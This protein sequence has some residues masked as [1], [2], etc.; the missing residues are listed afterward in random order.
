MLIHKSGKLFIQL[1]LNIQNIILF[2]YTNNCLA[3]EYNSID[4]INSLNEKDFPN[5]DYNNKPYFAEIM[6]N[7]T[8]QV[9][10]PVKFQCVVE[11]LGT[12]QVAWVRKD[13]HTLLA[14]GKEVISK[15]SR[16]D[17]SNHTDK[18][19]SLKLDPVREEDRGE[20]MCQ[21]N[22]SP[23]IDQ[24]AFLR[25][26]VPPYFVED[27][28]SSDTDVDENDSVSLRCTA[29]GFPAPTIEW[30]REDKESIDALS[31]SSISSSSDNKNVRTV[32][33]TFLNLSQVRRQHMGVYLCIA[34]NGIPNSVSKRIFLGV[35][36]P[37]LVWTPL[38]RVGSPLNGEVTLNCIVDAYPKPDCY[39]MKTSTRQ[40][41]LDNSKYSTSITSN[42]FK[43]EVTLTIKNVDY[44]DFTSYS[45]VGKN[46]LSEASG[47]IVLFEIPRPSTQRAVI[48][49]ITSPPSKEV[50]KNR[51]NYLGNTKNSLNSDSSDKEKLNF[52][53]FKTNS[54]KNDIPSEQ[55]T[56]QTEDGVTTTDDLTESMADS[57]SKELITSWSIG[58][59]IVSHLMITFN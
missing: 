41:I 25:V 46:V 55:I 9:G 1:I 59:L 15:N 42:S 22:S 29:R 20:Y 2:T 16:I 4:S 13:K 51:K 33:G 54:Y 35:K 44:Q 50:T 56:M 27:Q 7:V 24:S 34:S 17:V 3:K 23:V 30:R 52:A 53:S 14:L 32:Q 8:V 19:F 28:T 21:I 43:Y 39:W 45:C 49:S 37:P 18:I 40:I 6:S 31:P 26:T 12:R 57:S 36:F 11:N 5:E 58:F 48:N 10:R 38:Q 47:T